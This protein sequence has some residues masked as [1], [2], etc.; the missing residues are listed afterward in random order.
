MACAPSTRLTHRSIEHDRR[1]ATASW[2]LFALALATSLCALAL[3]AGSAFAATFGESGEEAGQLLNGQGIAI[4]QESGDVYLAD[5][6]SARLEKW[7]PAGEFLLAWGWG[8]ADGAGEPQTCGPEATPPHGA[9]QAGTPG[10]GPGQLSKFVGS[11]VAV[12]NDLL[13][14]SHGD[15]YVADTENERVDKYGPNGEFLLTFG[16]AVNATTNAN[17]C[18][19]GE[20][21]QAGT[22]GT[23]PGEFTLEAGNTIAVDP[24]GVVYVGD[25]NRVQEFNSN[26]D[27]EGEVALPGTG[28]IEQLAVGST[29]D[30]YAMDTETSGV[31]KY[32]SAGVELGEPRAPS[33]GG[34]A[35]AIASGPSDGLI[36]DDGG[37][38]NGRHVSEFASS[39][40]QTTSFLEEAAETLDV[41]TGM[42][43]GTV[44]DA[45]YVNRQTEVSIVPVPGPGPV[46]AGESSAALMPTTATVNATVNPEGQQTKYTFEY[47]PTAAYGQSSSTETLAGE[48]FE[49]ASA[50]ASLTELQP[51]TTYHFRIVATNAAGTT[52]GPDQTFAT[53]P[54][55]LIEDVAAVRVTSESA[56][57]TAEIDPLGLAT[58]YRFEYGTTASY[59]KRVPVPAASVGA[60]S[61]AVQLTPILI[62]PLA[63]ETTYH[64]RVVTENALGKV[65]GVDRTFRTPAKQAAA[66]PDG[67]AWELVSPALKHGA[68]LE[69]MTEEGGIIQAA[70]DGSGVTYLASAP[71]DAEPQGNRSV[72]FTQV[73]A[74]RGGSGWSSEDIATAHEAVAGYSVGHADEYLLFSTDLR[75]GL[76]EPRGETPLAPGVTERTPY[77]RETADQTFA[78]LLTLTD[79]TSGEPWAFE[80]FV[81]AS[82]DL[83]HIIVHSRTSLLEPSFDAEERNSLYEWTAGQLTPVS[84]LPSGEPAATGITAFGGEDRVK[85]AVSDDGSR[86]V[87]TAGPGEARHI[88][89]RDLA[90]HETVQLDEVQPGTVGRGGPDTPLY[91][92]ASADG[93]R[94]YFTDQ[95]RLTPNATSKAGLPDLYLCELK[96]VGAHLACALSDLTADSHPPEAAG[97]QESVIG[98]A[99]DGSHPFFVARGVLTSLSNAAGEH[100]VAG[101]ENLYFYDGS[102]HEDRLV[103]VLSANDAE[104]WLT[105]AGRWLGAPPRTARVSPNGRYIAF[106]SERSLTGYDNHDLH[107]GMPDEEV[108]LFDASTGTTVCVSCNPTGERPSGV[109]DSEERYPGP[110]FDH[111]RAWL[112]RWIAASVPGWTRSEAS[113]ILYQSR[114]LSDSGRL[115][116]DSSDAL[117]PRDGN[118]KTDVYEYEPPGVGGCTTSSVTFGEASGG[119]V[120]LISSGT[121]DDESVFMDASESG[122]DVFFLTA[123]QLVPA[124]VDGALDLYDAHVCSAALPC[125]ASATTV[126]P[127]CSTADSC[128]AAPPP[129]PGTFGPPASAT[130]SGAG[131]VHAPAP[132]KPPAKPLTRAQKLAKALKACRAKRK[133]ARALCEA[134]ARKRYGAKATTRKAADKRR[135]K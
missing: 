57:L 114:Y 91:E 51:R 12:D 70:A 102:A 11:G 127:A 105:E 78:P 10:A 106:M 120:G 72:A 42:A 34:G 7:G 109:L 28:G 97:V 5:G 49:E 8:V 25:H 36:V 69:A 86:V 88:Y 83:R 135:G 122:D 131:N 116:F 95:R 50:S 98:A 76:V 31:H 118:G 30:F 123:S 121:S 20:Q 67:R 17:V 15:V 54:P 77:I 133:H 73:L 23:G 33:A 108:F 48:A 63:P 87:F 129:Q 130:L 128:R 85:H 134:Q 9:C 6:T 104:D 61:T 90:R 16:G 46:V 18:L 41:P 19:A 45:L 64:Y 56:E 43:F 60:R 53:L 82:P 14:A 24:A 22:P 58:T 37:A 125:P 99:E 40:A 65:D 113:R 2:W 96:V 117:V 52:D 21:C 29:S 32:S 59:E 103:A 111:E 71:I 35:T 115:F 84:I 13:S 55:A 119:C 107:S 126:P 1:A 62:E 110:L 79:V 3:F 27:F 74:Q 38:E 75:R 81:G 47:G 112:G 124:D 68:S 89:T 44:R 92:T 39:G 94:V 132:A 100:A 93:S 26:S 4:D 101:G 66:L 80:P